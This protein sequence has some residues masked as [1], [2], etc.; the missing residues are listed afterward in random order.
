[1]IGVVP[2]HEGAVSDVYDA[3][4]PLRRGL[5][6]L[7][8]GDAAGAEKVDQLRAADPTPELILR[9][10]DDWTMEDVIGW[11]L[12][13]EDSDSLTELRGRINCDFESIDELV[14]L[15]RSRLVP[16]A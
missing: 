12:K 13:G 11:I 3:L 4:R 14:C 1:M 2:T 5:V 16:A 6:P 9:W 10:R 7:V 8:D 15:S